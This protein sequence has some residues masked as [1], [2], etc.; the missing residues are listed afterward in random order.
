MKREIT[1]VKVGGNVIDSQDAL[2]EFISVFARIPGEK[3]LVHGGG[4]V[5]T[6]IA[7]KLGVESQMIEGRRVTGD[8]MIDVA[9]MTYAGLVNK[10]IVALLQREGIAAFGLTGADGNSILAE[11][12]PLQDGIDYGWVG[13]IT[14]VNAGFIQQLL[15]IGF[16]P[17]FCALTH[18][19]A[20]QML[21]TNADTIANEIAIA[22]T[23]HFEV[24]LNYCFELPG[25]LQNV[26]EPKSLI[27][28]MNFPG[29]QKLKKEGIVSQGMVPKLDNAFRAL[30]EG[31]NAVNI[32]NMDS[33]SQLINNKNHDGYTRLY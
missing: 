31:V 26:A 32:L 10:K 11:K 14:R 2:L 13:D 12:R 23:G 30:S 20:G 19:G 29:Y 17:I 8:E 1:V 25:V 24:K 7:S 21:N 4:K 33:L 18:D 16:T 15:G 6:Q 5:A 3:L 28:E 9:V 22:L 27:K